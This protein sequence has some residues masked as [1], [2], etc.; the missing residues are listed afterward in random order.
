VLQCGSAWP[1]SSARGAASARRGARQPDLRG[2]ASVASSARGAVGATRSARGA[3]TLGVRP[4]GSSAQ[5]VQHAWLLSLTAS[6]HPCACDACLVR[7]PPPMS[8]SFITVRPW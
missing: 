6:D 8:L 1:A 7:A 2:V 5:S 4:G 3:A